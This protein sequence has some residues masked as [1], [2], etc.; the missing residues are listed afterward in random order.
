MMARDQLLSDLVTTLCAVVG[1]SMLPRGPNLS[2]LLVAAVLP[3]VVAVL[4][5]VVAELLEVVSVLLLVVAVLFLVASPPAP[6]S[7]VLVVVVGADVSVVDM[8][9]VQ[10][11]SQAS[12]LVK[13]F[14]PEQLRKSIDWQ[15]KVS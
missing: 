3:D 10:M 15:V 11:P 5:L 4:L 8:F 9:A 7:G 6:T 12:L 2:L 1:K 13:S 14:C